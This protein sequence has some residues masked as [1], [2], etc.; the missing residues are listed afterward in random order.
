MHII[1]SFNS[2][3]LMPSLVTIY[4]LFM[5]NEGVILHIFYIDL[6]DDERRCVERLLKMKTSHS[7]VWHL[8][9]EDLTDKIHYDTGRF[10]MYTLYRFLAYR[11]LDNSIKRCLWLDS[12]LMI[13]GS[14]RELYDTI[15]E[16][17]QYFTGALEVSQDMIR[18]FGELRECTN[19]G[20][21]L[22]DLEKLRSDDMM[23]RYWEYLFDSE[24][25]HVLPDQ[26]ALNHVFKGKIKFVDQEVW[27]RFPITVFDEEV[28]MEVIQMKA[29]KARIIHFLSGNKVWLEEYA[30]IWEA[31]AEKIPFVKIMYEEYLGYLDECVRFLETHV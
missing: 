29:D 24:I 21:L 3:F 26:D 15:M 19:A 10:S 9:E 2:L 14:V 1:M 28:P 30:P 5:Y 23:D 4:T 18:R 20:V 6:K 16:E 11:I 22:M 27:N 7:I 13:R 25:E 17:G 31:R 8:V 12:D